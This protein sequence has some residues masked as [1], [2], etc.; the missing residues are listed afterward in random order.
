[1]NDKPWDFGD[2]PGVRPFNGITDAA[3]SILWRD[4]SSLV[5]DLTRT[6]FELVCEVLGIRPA[7]PEL[8]PGVDGNYTAR[9]RFSMYTDAE[10]SRIQS[11]LGD[12][13]L[14]NRAVNMSPDDLR[15]YYMRNADPKDL[16]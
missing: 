15:E 10:L 5:I 9:Q 14:I 6:Q 2:D 1:M 11:R 13:N 4:G 8:I 12:A 16:F 3:L 7:A